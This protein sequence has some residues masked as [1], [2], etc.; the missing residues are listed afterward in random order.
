[1]WSSMTHSQLGTG[2]LPVARPYRAVDLVHRR[3]P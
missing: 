2:P 3:L 1:M